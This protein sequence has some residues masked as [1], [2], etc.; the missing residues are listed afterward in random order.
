MTKFGVKNKEFNVY[1]VDIKKMLEVMC[2]ESGC[3]INYDVED[4]TSQELDKL[5]SSM[6][7]QENL[8]LF[9]EINKLIQQ[10]KEL[11]KKLYDLETK[12]AQDE[13]GGKT[14]IFRLTDILSEKSVSEKNVPTFGIELTKHYSNLNLKLRSEIDKYIEL[15]KEINLK[16][17]KV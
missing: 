7:K 15:L 10:V 16:F 9:S 3:D 12:K 8:L 17:E 11:N 1:D 6:Q 5:T 14:D 13:E 2:M 4:L